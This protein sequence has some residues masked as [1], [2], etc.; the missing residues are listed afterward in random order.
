M[1]NIKNIVLVCFMTGLVLSTSANGDSKGK[2]RSGSWI[3]QSQ[4]GGNRGGARVINDP[5]F[6]VPGIQLPP[7]SGGGSGQPGGLGSGGG[8][9]KLPI[10]QIGGS[11]SGGSS[12]I[13]NGLGGSQGGRIKLPPGGFPQVRIPSPINGGGSRSPAP[14]QVPPGFGPNLQD[15]LKP[16][17]GDPSIIKPNPGVIDGILDN[18]NGGNGGGGNGGGGCNDPDV[19]IWI[20]GFFNH[21]YCPAPCPVPG[22]CVPIVTVPSPIV[23]GPE[24]VPVPIEV[25]ASSA[26]PA[27]ENGVEL[28]LLISGATEV[29]GKVALVVN[30]QPVMVEVTAWQPGV[31]TVQMPTLLLASEVPAAIFVADAEAKVIFSTEIRI[32]LPAVAV[33]QP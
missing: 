22:F 28:T 11:S 12:V 26:I 16:K 27:V 4:T 8:R 2:G 32:V 5:S 15:I 1:R 7:A 6:K 9:I 23:V 18:L 29:Q 21:G 17:P 3:G 25:P 13:S 19:H 24:I 33:Q 31:V 30:D 10:P 20:E 14:I